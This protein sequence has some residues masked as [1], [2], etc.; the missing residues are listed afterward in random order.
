MSSLKNI[1]TKKSRKQKKY[2]LLTIFIFTILFSLYLF[3]NISKIF[4]FKNIKTNIY[5]IDNEDKKVQIENFISK[6]IKEDYNIFS[7][8]NFFKFRE[9][10]LKDK[11]NTNFEDI[12]KIEIHRDLNLSLLVNI[13]FYKPVF[14]ACALDEGML[15]ACM[16]SDISGVFKKE[17]Q[18]KKEGLYFVEINKGALNRLESNKIDTEIDSL[19][20]TRLFAEKDIQLLFEYAKYLEKQNYKINKIYASELKNITFFTDDF[21][22]VFSLKKGFVK[23]VKEYEFITQNE[24][25]QTLINNNKISS[26]DFSYNDKVFYKI[27]GLGAKASSTEAFASTTKIN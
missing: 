19:V 4:Y 7:Q 6:N 3:L 10:L 14:V 9:N 22:I 20:D 8:N 13:Y 18:G 21:D 16:S 2:I 25:I 11:L 5:G 24:K 27:K 17:E 12:D 26:L 23:S 1:N 15:I